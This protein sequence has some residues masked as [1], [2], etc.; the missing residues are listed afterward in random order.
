MY[1]KVDEINWPQWVPK[2]RATLLFIIRQ[3][4]ILLIH[5]KRGLGAGKING[6][7][8]RL[9]PGETP[10]EAAIR[11][12]EE[13]VC[14]TPQNVRPAGEL[15]FQFCDGYSLHGYVFTATDYTGTLAETD[16]ARPEWFPLDSIPYKRMW[17]DDEFWMPLM[18]KNI[19]F[20]GVFIFDNDDMLDMK[21]VQDEK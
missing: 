2:E 15:L 12:V 5:K 3:G 9:D 14:V 17:P 1:S 8:G 4:R 18:L 20:R 21:L 10:V 19:W 6:P 7:G 11:E 16:E 13:E